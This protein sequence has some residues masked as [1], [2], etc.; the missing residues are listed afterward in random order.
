M[1]LLAEARL[2]ALVGKMQADDPEVLTV[3]QMVRMLTIDGARVLGIDG[4]LG[5]VEV[6]KRADLVAFD[7]NRLECTPAHDLASNLVYSMSPRSVRDVL[8]DG[9]LLVRNGRL[10]RDDEA[11]LA[12]R[13]R[14]IIG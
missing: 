3:Q 13:H 11:A 10:V 4:L 1:D 14:A 9:D 5:S 6:G 12:R 8:V 2:A 7:T